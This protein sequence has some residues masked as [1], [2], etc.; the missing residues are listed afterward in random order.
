[1]LIALGT[2]LDFSLGE[3]IHKEMIEKFGSP[4]EIDLN[5][6]RVSDDQVMHLAT[7]DAL[8]ENP[9]SLEELYSVIAR[10]YVTVCV[11]S[12]LHEVLHF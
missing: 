8:V 12:F 2:A 4:S 3:D 7:A 5:G 6:W 9:P 10:H 11:L 1:M